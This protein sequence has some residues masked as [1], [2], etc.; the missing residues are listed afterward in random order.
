MRS[1]WVHATALFEARSAAGF[2]PETVEGAV[3]VAF[4]ETKTP[5]LSALSHRF[6]PQGFSV[7]VS[8]PAARVLLH[9]W[10]E[11]GVATLDLHA[12]GE[13][14]ALALM[15]ALT[16]TLGWTC[17]DLDLRVRDP[18]EKNGDRLLYPGKTGI[19]RTAFK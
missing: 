3:A 16:R 2:A 4:E 7:M 14:A 18:R 1:E 9:T 13:A 5:R 19:S 15:K 11:R 17:T 8:G 10:P 6:E 12:S